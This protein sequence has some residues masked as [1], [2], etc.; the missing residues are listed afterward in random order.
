M[1]HKYWLSALFM[2]LFLTGLQAQE[3]CLKPK[4]QIDQGVN[5]LTQGKINNVI[6]K[7]NFLY[8]HNTLLNTDQNLENYLKP[9]EIFI[10]AAVFI[11]MS[12]DGYLLAHI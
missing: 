2:G 10:V 9:V 11:T 12:S 7:E 3:E 6:H 1:K 8:F 5:R 4:A